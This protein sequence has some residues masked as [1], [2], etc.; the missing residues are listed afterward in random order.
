MRGYADRM[1]LTMAQLIEETSAALVASLKGHLKKDGAGGALYRRLSDLLRDRIASGELAVGASLPPQRQLSAALGLSEVTVRRAL[2]DLAAQGYITAQA[3]RGTTVL[4]RRAAE[5]ASPSRE[6]HPLS[7]GIAFS[8]LADGYPFIQP[9]LKGIR[10]DAGHDVSVKLFD[11]PR[12]GDVSAALPELSTLDGVL[13]MSPVNISLL[14]QCQRQGLPCV[15]MYTDIADGYSHCIVVDYGHGV[16]EAVTHLT[17]RGRGDIALITATLDRFSTGQLIDAYRTAL[18]ANGLTYSPDRVTHTGYQ[19]RH[20]YEAL[21]TM[22]ADGHTPQAVLCASD[23]QA[24]GVLLAAHE[25]GLR[26]PDDLAVIG[27]GLLLDRHGWPT[28]LTSIDLRLT[29]VGE[30]ARQLVEQALGKPDASTPYRTSVRSSLVIG[31]TT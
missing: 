25:A 3:G 23:Y 4:S 21:R 6:G 17:S 13:M 12:A 20:G 31:Q 27:A 16:L 18:E 19:E 8:D 10:A 11:L 1:G 24:R 2:Q 15:L 30:L 28:Q 5:P 7:L 22:I 14:A 9:M 26:V 29:K